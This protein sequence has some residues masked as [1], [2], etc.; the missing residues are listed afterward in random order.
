MHRKINLKEEE[1]KW[2]RICKRVERCFFECTLKRKVKNEFE[3][4][5]MVF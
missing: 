4:K 3:N 1:K 5:T 2:K